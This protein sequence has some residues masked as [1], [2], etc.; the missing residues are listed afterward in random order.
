MT[1]V[2]QR[3]GCGCGGREG[4]RGCCKS[5]LDTL[6]VCGDGE[7]EEG[8]YTADEGTA[9]L[10]NG[11]R[12]EGDWLG[13]ASGKK[14]RGGA[15]AFEGEGRRGEEGRDGGGHGLAAGFV[16]WLLSWWETGGEEGGTRSFA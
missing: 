14:R 5:G 6:E 4:R 11:G 3:R 8:G 13:G 10:E 12:G 16:L 15:V 1:E 9:R 7:S 2:E